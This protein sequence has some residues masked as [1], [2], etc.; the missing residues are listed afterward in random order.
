M[1]GNGNVLEIGKVKDKQAPTLRGT[2]VIAAQP[3]AAHENP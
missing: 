1:T 2:E 3:E